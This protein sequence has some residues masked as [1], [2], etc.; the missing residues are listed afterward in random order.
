MYSFK[1]LKAD[2]EMAATKLSKAEQNIAFFCQ[3]GGLSNFKRFI[4][5]LM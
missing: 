2:F 3:G 1:M 5:L 4:F